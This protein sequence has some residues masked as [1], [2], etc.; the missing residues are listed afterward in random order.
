MAVVHKLPGIDLLRFI[1]RHQIRQLH[2][3]VVLIQLA[4]RKHEILNPHLSVHT[5][6]TRTLQNCTPFSDF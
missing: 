5:I 4:I 6:H 3:L 1:P 2:P